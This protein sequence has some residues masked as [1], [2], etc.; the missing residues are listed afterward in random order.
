MAALPEIKDDSRTVKAIYSAYEK[1]HAKEKRMS[2]RLGAS[3]IGKECA[4]QVWYDFRWATES[5]FDGRVLRLFQT[6][7]IEEARIAQ[8]LIDIGCEVSLC[9]PVTKQQYE[10]TA[11]SGHVVCKIDAAVLGLPEA[12]KTWH[13]GEFKTHNAKSF[14][15]VK[16]KGIKTAKPEHYY[17]LGMGMKLSGMERGIYFAVNKDADEIYTERI[18]WEE[19]KTDIDGIVARAE[20][21]VGAVVPPEKI[22][23]DAEDFR[24]RF[25]SHKERCHGSQVADV[26]CRTCVHAEAVIEEGGTGR[27]MCKKHNRALSVQE[28]VRACD[29]HLYIP[30]LV[31]FATVDDGGYDV[32][33]D[34]VSYKN[35]DGTTWRNSKQRGDYKS[36]E[37]TQLA[38]HLVGAGMI[39]AAKDHLGAEVVAEV[40]A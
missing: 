8:N 40:L 39:E 6:G 31:P 17:Q 9:D 24:C 21:I 16:V 11:V 28:Q 27:W 23:K 26:N 34:W 36:L 15:G 3:I 14:A 38:H 18:R 33:G 35:A 10:F 22:A 5:V 12:P 37:L 7:D 32:A 2:R 20:S 29:D 30:D 19:I 13:A 4:R 25:C 1:R